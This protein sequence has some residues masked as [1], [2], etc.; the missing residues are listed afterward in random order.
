MQI[1]G[2]CLVGEL[3]RGIPPGPD[4]NGHVAAGTVLPGDKLVPILAAHISRPSY[5][6]GMETKR[7]TLIGDFPRS[8]W[9]RDGGAG[10]VGIHRI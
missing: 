9:A 7:I 10:G 5:A 3:L 1:R 4:I 8:S 6:T 2:E